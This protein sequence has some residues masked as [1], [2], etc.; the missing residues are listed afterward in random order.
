MD[1]GQRDAYAA[2][3]NSVLAFKFLDD[4]ERRFLFD[5]SEIFHVKDGELFIKEGELD[6]YLYIVLQGSANVTV[7]RDGKEV[8]I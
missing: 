2:V 6:S 8:Y 3:F 4:E 5:R 7:K 1:Q